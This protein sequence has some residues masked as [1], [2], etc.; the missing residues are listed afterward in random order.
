MGPALQLVEGLAQRPHPVGPG[1]SNE[2]I[3]LLAVGPLVSP[4]ELTRPHLDCLKTASLT[5]FQRLEAAP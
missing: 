1:V 5:L 3:A 2:A 4:I